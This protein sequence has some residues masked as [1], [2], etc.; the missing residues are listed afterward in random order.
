MRVFVAIELLSQV[1]DERVLSLLQFPQGSWF[2]PTDASIK[3]KV[4]AQ[5]RTQTRKARSIKGI[6][7][8]LDDQTFNEIQV[9][10]DFKPYR[11]PAGDFV[12]SEARQVLTLSPTN[13]MW[14]ATDQWPE[15][16]P[17][18]A[19]EH[20]TLKSKEGRLAFHQITRYPSL[21]ETRLEVQGAAPQHVEAW[22]LD[23]F[24][25]SIS[26]TIADIEAFGGGGVEVMN[27]ETETFEMMVVG[28]ETALIRR[29][30][31]WNQLGEKFGVLQPLMVG[32]YQLCDQLS[33]AVHE[34][35]VYAIPASSPIHRMGLVSISTASLK[36]QETQTSAKPFLAF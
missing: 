24:A 26:E 3:A 18:V 4:R 21:L 10:R 34:A 15:R 31:A 23:A 22:L 30:K 9:S 19:R 36:S 32:R 28:V 13:L 1:Q 11:V 6:T 8:Q 29:P 25:D 33:R 20:A 14:A 27:T 16:G 2:W 7:D 5:G 12:V 35:K 17:I